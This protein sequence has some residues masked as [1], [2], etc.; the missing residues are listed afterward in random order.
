MPEPVLPIDLS[1]S[2]GLRHAATR[3]AQL[4]SI[5]HDIQAWGVVLL[6]IEDAARDPLVVQW[7]DAATAIVGAVRSICQRTVIVTPPPILQG[8]PCGKWSFK[9]PRRW[10]KRVPGML[11]ERVMKDDDMPDWHPVSVVSLDAMPDDLRADDVWPTAAG[12]DWMADQ[13]AAGLLQMTDG[14]ED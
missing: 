4:L 8:R 5:D 13:V 10:A 7:L 11:V 9:E 3:T 14:T 12:Y 6:G 1:G 2:G